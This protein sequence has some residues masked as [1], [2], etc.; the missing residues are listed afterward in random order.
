MR[1]RN[2][3]KEQTTTN[4]RN[5]NGNRPKR[6]GTETPEP[7]LPKQS[8]TPGTPDKLSSTPGGAQTNANNNTTP[9]KKSKALSNTKSLEVKHET[10]HKR[11]RHEGKFILFRSNTK[12]LR[13]SIMEMNNF[14]LKTFF[15]YLL[16]Y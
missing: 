7:K 4:N 3:T 9:N 13:S 6:G 16:I 2:K 15:E 5:A 14:R 8:N 1:T 11:K 12:Y 10:P